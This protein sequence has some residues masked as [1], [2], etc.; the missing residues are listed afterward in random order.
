MSVFFATAACLNDVQEGKMV[1]E[2][3]VTKRPDL[4]QCYM[5]PKKAVL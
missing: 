2:N 5:R 3:Q 4:Q 1:Y